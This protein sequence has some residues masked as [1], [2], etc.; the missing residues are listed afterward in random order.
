MLKK[1]KDI[2]ISTNMVLRNHPK[3][4]KIKELISS[5]QIG[6]IYHI[7][8]E[9]NYGRFHKLINGWRGK[10]LTTLLWPEGESTSSIFS[11][12]M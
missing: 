11:D 9:Y 10:F 12:G 1:N 2:K 5:G 4:L 7:E 3:F 6:K 8:G